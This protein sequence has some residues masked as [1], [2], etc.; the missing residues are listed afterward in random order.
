MKRTSKLTAIVL[1]TTLAVTTAWVGLESTAEARGRGHGPM[2][3]GMGEGPHQKLFKVIKQLDLRADQRVA[4]ESLAKDMKAKCAPLRKLRKQAMTEVAAGVRAGKID[5]AQVQALILQA[6]A[7]AESLK[8]DF[9]T[10]LNKL[11]AILD[12]AQR[13]QLVA[14]IKEKKQEG[15]KG[16]RGKHRG[17]MAK[18]AKQLNLTEAQQ[19]QIKAAMKAQ[20]KNRGKDRSAMSGKDR[21]AMSGK[22]QQRRADMK[23]AAQAFTSDTFDARSL[24]LFQKGPGKSH[25]KGM[26]M[27]KM[28]ETILPILTETQ[29]EQLATIIDKRAARKGRRSAQ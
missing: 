21:S 17:K 19:E 26:R 12:P 18:M 28:S 11:H 15:F 1:G 7:S 9:Q 22:W 23:A 8:P 24:A 5:K 20:F 6:K 2:M 14:L 13:T 10:S 27:V 4:V 16:M 3:G 25:H 29:R